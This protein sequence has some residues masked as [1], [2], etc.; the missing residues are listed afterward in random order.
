MTIRT[1]IVAP[2]FDEATGFSYEWSRE[3]LEDAVANGLDIKDLSK[4]YAT[5]ENLYSGLQE[6]NPILF[7][8]YDHGNEDRIYAQDGTI[9]IDLENAVWLKG[10]LTY[11]MNC[12]SASKLGDK[13]IELGGVAYI[14]YIREFGFLT[15]EPYVDSFEDSANSGAKVLHRDGTGDDAASTIYDTFTKWIDYYVVGEGKDLPWAELAA[16]WLTH[17]R[18]SLR[19][20]GDGS[21]RLKDIPEPP[22]ISTPP[23]TPECPVSKFIEAM[24]GRKTLSFLRK[25]RDKIT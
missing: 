4:K 10:R 3:V 19:L 24:F 6:H 16:V 20:K 23:P 17:D 15:I 13:V 5:K 1:L 18:D 22:S 9:L 21:K 7:Y 8:H 2:S 11:C 14:G 12:L 25:I